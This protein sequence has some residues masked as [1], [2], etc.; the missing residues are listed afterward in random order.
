MIRK[1]IVDDIFLIV[2]MAYKFYQETAFKGLKFDFFKVANSL[3]MM[4]DSPDH[5]LL[6]YEHEGRVVGTLIA[7]AIETTFSTDKVTVELMWW[8][9]PEHRGNKEGLELLET[10]EQ[11]AQET[12]CKLITMACFDDRIGEFYTKRGYMLNE[13]NYIKWL[14]QL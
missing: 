14:P 4:V 6:M 5:L 3:S 13:R 12:G 9:D 7:S 2:G 10:Y 1:A 8:V 11:W